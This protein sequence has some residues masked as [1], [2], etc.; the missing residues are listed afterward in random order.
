M[1]LPANVSVAEPAAP[2]ATPRESPGVRGGTSQVRPLRQDQ[3]LARIVGQNLGGTRRP[4]GSRTDRFRLRPESRGE[5]LS[6][7]RSHPEPCPD[8]NVLSGKCSQANSHPVPP[9]LPVLR[10]FEV[11]P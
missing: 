5:S 8:A 3:A 1:P 7:P 10:D 9:S 6:P 11:F 4:A 2:K